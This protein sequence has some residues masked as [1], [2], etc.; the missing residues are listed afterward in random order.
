MKSAAH[1]PA[2]TARTYQ[3]IVEGILDESW[4]A[5]LGE[6][7]L[8]SQH[9]AAGRCLTT[10]QGVI[11]D[12]AALRGVLNRLWDLNL[13]LCSVQQIDPALTQTE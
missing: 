3:F 7:E 5:W 11:R 2:R 13:A 4:A 10:L 6:L 9:Q 8:V 12:Q 1:R